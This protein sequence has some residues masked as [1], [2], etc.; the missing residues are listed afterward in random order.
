MDFGA[1]TTV[2]LP[3]GTIRYSQRSNTASIES[4]RSGRLVSNPTF[5][6]VTG[7]VQVEGNPVLNPIPAI[8]V[9]IGTVFGVLS[10]SDG[11]FDPPVNAYP[12][13]DVWVTVPIGG[14][15][16]FGDYYVKSIAYGSIDLLKNPLT[17][18]PTTS[19]AITV[20]LALGTQITG[21]VRTES[22][23]PANIGVYLIPRTPVEERPDLPRR[24]DTDAQGNFVLRG[25]AP[26]EYDLFSES[27]LDGTRERVAIN[28]STDPISPLNLI[29]D[30]QRGL[31]AT[32]R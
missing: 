2:A 9:R 5:A 16:S 19:R 8:P 31:R 20:T 26:G 25:V 17:L 21:N 28:V 29:I 3:S 11:T 1:A 4:Y 27:M 30:A 23:N 22:G 7:K 24:A 32:A 12:T 18:D 6:V 15:D 13:K 10:R 14:R